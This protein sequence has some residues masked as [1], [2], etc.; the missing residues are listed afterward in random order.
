MNFE[1]ISW[2]IFRATGDINSYMLHREIKNARE[3][4]WTASKQE[5][6]SQEGQTTQTQT[7]F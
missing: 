6:S 7:V 1:E 4:E 2:D 5:Q 3:K